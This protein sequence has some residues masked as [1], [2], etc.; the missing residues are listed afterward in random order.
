MTELYIINELSVMR[1]LLAV[2]RGKAPYVLEVEALFPPLQG[3]IQR[4]VD[5]LVRSGRARDVVDLCP[6]LRHTREFP[7][8]LVVHDVFAETEGWQNRHFRFDET[9]KEEPDYAMAY[10]IVVCNYMANKH[11]TVLAIN[12]VLEAFGTGDVRVVGLPG[13]TAGLF[14]AYFGRPPPGPSGSGAFA[15]FFLNLLVAFLHTT[16]GMLWSLSRITFKKNRFENIFLLADFPGNLNDLPIFRELKDGGPQVLVLRGLARVSAK[17]RSHLKEFKICEADEGVFTSGGGL[18]AVATILGDGIRL[19]RR[20]RGCPPGLFYQVAALPFRRIKIRALLSRFRPAF[21]WGRD[22]YNPEHILRRQEQAR[23]GGQS[24]GIMSGFGGLTD[25]Y[26]SLRHISFDRYYVFGRDIFEK[27]YKDSWAPDMEVVASGSFSL[28]REDLARLNRPK[29]GIKDI[30]IFT[31]FLSQMENTEARDMV[32][33]LGEAFPDRTVRVQVRDYLDMRQRDSAMQFIESCTEGLDNV[34][35]ASE[36]LFDLVEKSRYAFSEPSTVIMES[37]QFNVCAFMMDVF[38]FQKTSFFRSYPGLSVRTPE[39]AVARIRDIESGA[40]S[41]PWD[42]L[43]GLV[44]MS[45]EPI[46]DIIRRGFDL[47][48]VCHD[49][50]SNRQLKSL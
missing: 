24:H 17:V 43:D 45:G 6:R 1:F 22:P 44:N 46:C 19:Y 28:T 8:T 10:K 36:P 26:P 27:I 38:P 41:Y 31:S 39:E 37:I 14:D 25:L 35:Y 9:D 48:V 18:A 50:P 15:G 32:R 33:A 40:W 20:F 2:F 7:I 42:E 34:I 13:D 12:D 4:L 23:L 47:P 11:L 5:A 29:Q 21:T 49:T 30:V 3:K 16:F